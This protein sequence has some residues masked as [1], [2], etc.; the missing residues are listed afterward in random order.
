MKRSILKAKPLKRGKVRLKPKNLS[1]RRIRANKGRPRTQ[2]NLRKELEATQKQLTILLYGNDCYTCPKKN[3]EGKNCQLGHVPWPRSKISIPAK[4]STNYT[5]IQCYDCNVNG[6]GMGGTA[7]LR[8]QKEGK[9][10]EIMWMKSQED[11][12]KT[13]NNKWFEQR[14]NENKELLARLS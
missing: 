13:F 6:G 5:R 2:S 1:N 4:F 7:T 9:D 12:G 14:I 10:V 3:L 8:M 11:K